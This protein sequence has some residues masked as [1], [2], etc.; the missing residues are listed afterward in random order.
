[1]NFKIARDFHFQ[2][3]FVLSQICALMCIALPIVSSAKT[4]STEVSVVISIF[5]FL[6]SCHL[7]IIS[8][9]FH[10][11]ADFDAEL[12]HPVVLGLFT[13]PWCDGCVAIAPIIET[14]EQGEN[15]EDGVVVLR[16]RTTYCY[17]RGTNRHF[18]NVGSLF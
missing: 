4:V 9:F 16:V 11:Q 7:I 5:E 14:Y 13:A 6:F 15:L 2:F 3:V 8:Y 1:M 18:V 12:N 10:V 17:N